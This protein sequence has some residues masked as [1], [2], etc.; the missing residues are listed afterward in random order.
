MSAGAAIEAVLRVIDAR[1]ARLA[2]FRA[3]FAGQTASGVT[4]RRLES[5][6]PDGEPYA[7]L[8]GFAI[9]ANAE[10][11]CLPING[12]P[13]VL[14]QLWRQGESA[15][16]LPGA[17]RVA[18]ASPSVAPGNAAG[19]GATATV[20]WGSDTAFQVTIVTGGSGVGTGALASV[21]F[22]TARGGSSYVP[23]LQELSAA[24][25]D[26]NLY[27]TGRSSTGFSIACRTNPG[28]GATLVVGVV[29]VGVE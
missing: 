12:K 17:L 5:S 14:G 20:N 19:N 29:V 9:P 15:L 16:T 4:I 8:A 13:V 7:R 18:G 26:A 1:L 23:V 11:A 28:T 6:A 21:T 24:A 2:A 27:A 10:V 22:A 25:R 3:I